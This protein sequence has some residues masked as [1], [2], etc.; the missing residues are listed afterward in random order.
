MAV[1]VG[2]LA[3]A[4]MAVQNAMV[5]LALVDTP[6]T[7]VMT[8]NTTQLCIDLWRSARFGGF[9]R[10]SQSPP[11]SP[12]GVYLFGSIRLWLHGTRHEPLYRHKDGNHWVHERFGE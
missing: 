1:L 10:H 4:A 3:V 8:T 11:A 7:A 9:H 12:L 6:S 2:M 5:K